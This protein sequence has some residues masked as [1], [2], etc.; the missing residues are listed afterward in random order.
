MKNLK[1][2]LSVI[3]FSLFLGGI[4][5]AAFPSKQVQEKQVVVEQNNQ[6]TVIANNQTI[7]VQ[8]PQVMPESQSFVDDY[9]LVITVLLWVFLG[10]FAAHRWYKGRPMLANLLFIVTGG[11]FGIWYLIDL[12]NILTDKW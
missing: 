1:R 5:F 2:I 12:Y 7:A 3:T 10:V 4:A 6:K 9:E 11:G 8:S